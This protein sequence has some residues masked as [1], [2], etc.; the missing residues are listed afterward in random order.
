MIT[1]SLNQEETN[2]RLPSEL[3][4]FISCTPS[5]FIIGYW[6]RVAQWFM[7]PL[8]TKRRLG[9]TPGLRT[10]C[11]GFAC[12]P[13]LWFSYFFPRSQMYV[14]SVIN[15]KLCGC[16]GEWLLVSMTGGLS[17]MSS[18]LLSPCGSREKLQLTP[19][20]PSSGR[21]KCWKWMSG[22]WFIRITSLLHSSEMRKVLSFFCVLHS[23]CSLSTLVQL[24]PL[25]SP[26][27]Y[28]NLL[29]V[30]DNS[31]SQVF[32]LSGELLLSCGTSGSLC[33]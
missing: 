33:F 30:R 21:S 4:H 16:E 25:R 3:S 19:D 26:S 20:N 2:S 5:E 24:N 28:W 14:S 6:L 23:P 11:V 7:L 29:Q 17:R 18:I 32:S 22:Y 13:C 12:P 1:H 15:S 9:S 10:F 31:P 27:G 8:H